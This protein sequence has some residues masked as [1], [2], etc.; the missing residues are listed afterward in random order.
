MSEPILV[1]S[2]SG[3]PKLTQKICAYLKIKPA[4]NEVHR[5][6]EG[7]L[8]VHVCEN[9]RGR[10]IYL[11]Q[12]IAFPSNDNFV[13][14][15]FWID[16]FKRASAA[17]VTVIIPYFSYAKGDKKDEPRV[18]IRARVC[19]DAIENTGADRMVMMDLHAAQIQGFA[20]IPV[21]ELMAM[22]ILCE[23]IKRHHFKKLT[24]VSPDA[25]FAKKARNFARRLHCPLA[26]SDKLRLAHDEKAEVVSIIGDV[27][28]RTCLIVDDFTISGGTLAETAQ[29][30]LEKGAREVYAAITHGVFARG[31]MEK[32]AK[33]PLKKLF[34][35]DSVEAQPVQLS[36]RI[37]VVS[38]AP[39]F[40]EAIRRIHNRESISVL[41]PS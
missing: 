15:L 7:N 39:L 3:S 24:V 41:F 35:T 32:I 30:L 28:G 2:G 31:S 20:R 33:S 17:S 34:V 6:S 26:I 38:V 19:M 25:G 1:F 18:S 4:R 29:R 21:D 10:N 9:V 40:A 13:E 11:V 36:K 5:F 8:F 37:E 22:P 23:A 14:L 16:A 27:K 12:Q